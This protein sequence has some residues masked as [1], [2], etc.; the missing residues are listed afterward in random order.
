M[1]TGL[2]RFFGLGA[3]KRR[4]RR[5]V[6]ARSVKGVRCSV[7]GDAL[8]ISFG[9][10]YFKQALSRKRQGIVA[11][12]RTWWVETCLSDPG[13]VVRYGSV[14]W[15]ASDVVANRVWHQ[16]AAVCAA[17][18]GKAIS[19]DLPT[20]VGLAKGKGRGTHVRHGGVCPAS[21]REGSFVARK[22]RSGA[23]PRRG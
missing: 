1:L 2:G 3:A 10:G 23:S 18:A 15:T 7:Q 8:R 17:R 11:S 21:V 14:G 20:Y 9:P 22:V 13:Y 5:V 6:G 4:K 19:S 12:G 16:G